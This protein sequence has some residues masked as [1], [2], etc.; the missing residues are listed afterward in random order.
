MVINEK[1][2]QILHLMTACE[3]D[4]P[5]ESIF[6]TLDPDRKSLPEYVS[7]LR[8]IRHLTKTTELGVTLFHPSLMEFVRTHE[9]HRSYWKDCI[10]KTLAWLTS[11]SAPEYMRWAHEWRLNAQLDN[12][13]PLISGPSRSWAIDSVV[14]RFPTNEVLR[15]LSLSCQAALQKNRLPDYLYNALLRDYLEWIYEAQGDSLELLLDVQLK[16]FRSDNTL[17]ARLSNDLASL[18]FGE[19]LT[20][21]RHGRA[22]EDQDLARKILS[23]FQDRFE[24]SP[25]V[26]RLQDEREEILSLAA[27]CED[28]TA[29]NVVNYILEQEDQRIRYRLIDTYSEELRRCNRMKES[30]ILLGTDLNEAEKLVV[31]HHA[32]LLAL[33]QG[34]SP[35]SVF[36]NRV[37]TDPYLA[38]IAART[39]S[40]GICYE[41]HDFPSL[42]FNYRYS[43]HLYGTHEAYRKAIVDD[44]TEA[45]FLFV[46]N[47]IWGRVEENQYWLGGIETQCYGFRFLRKL[48]EVASDI[49]PY[50][51]NGGFAPGDLFWRRLGEFEKPD[52]GYDAETWD[53]ANALK[54][55]ATRITL[56]LILVGQAMGYRIEISQ[57]EL[58]IAFNSGFSDSDIWIKTYLAEDRKV[59]TN[60]AVRW[61]LD[62]CD[63]VLKSSIALFP[64]RSLDYARMAKLAT[65]HGLEDRAMIYVEAAASNLLGYGSHK[66]I[67]LFEALDAI[68]ECY[69]AGIRSAKDKL[70][71]LVPAILQVTEFT[72]GDLTHQILEKLADT[73]STIEP[74]LLPDYY[75]YLRSKEQNFAA[76]YVHENYLSVAECTSGQDKTNTG[77][78]NHANLIET[79]AGNKTQYGLDTLEIASDLASSLEVLPESSKNSDDCEPIS[80]RKPP[81][82]SRNPDPAEYPPQRFGE[83]LSNLSALQDRVLGSDIRVDPWVNYW[84]AKGQA[85]ETFGSLKSAIEFGEQYHLFDELFDL[86]VE[87][88]GTEQAFDWLVSIHSRNNGWRRG[89][90]TPEKVFQRWEKVKRFYPEK[91]V[92]FMLRSIDDEDRHLQAP[93]GKEKIQRMIK[94]CLFMEQRDLAEALTQVVTRFV[95]EVVSPLSLP[96]PD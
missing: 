9:D 33:E 19:L 17:V 81:D 85:R 68:T 36:T 40:N 10:K 14:K 34:L 93:Y 23:H 51:K 95:S 39:K 60:N 8:A 74:G 26:L 89:W 65:M 72:D 47:H 63:S 44:I 82:K 90:G 41:P 15:I 43:V 6:E 88:L 1:S 59:M 32:S 52:Y 73:F 75:K 4:W 78:A 76:S 67:L 24:Q 62:G 27:L 86:A 77:Q 70:V 13:D 21:A 94:Y 80:P 66:D 58:Q 46:A 69:K 53:I 18:S 57:T 83:Y 38:I 96:V 28:V 84:I 92:E 20:L 61:V 91:C 16:L 87:F 11:P 56:N 7:A 42:N 54:K 12:F 5:Q 3:F 79:Y 50:I 64:D 48:D 55:A 31:M 37:I 22:T 45:F 2:K 71:V 29:E 30:L 35:Y 25:F 49:A